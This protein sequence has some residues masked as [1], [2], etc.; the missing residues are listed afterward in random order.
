MLEPYG[1]GSENAGRLVQSAD[2][3]VAAA[4]EMGRPVALKVQSADIPHKTEAGAVILHLEGPDNVRAG[5]DAVL[6]A[7]KNFAPAAH[8][9]GVLVQR[10]APPGREVILGV[11]HDATFGPLLLVGLGGVLAEALGDV[12]VAPVPLD[13]GQARALIGRLKAANIFGRYRG[14]PPADIDALSLLM[15]RLSQF[16]H[17]HAEEILAIDLNPVIVHS[18]GDGVSVVDALITKRAAAAQFHLARE[19]E[20][21]ARVR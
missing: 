9:D 6:A 5:F 20:E 1:I 18:A 17:D 16:A 12:A 11:S 13:Q 14:L 7:A 3:A 10:M 4:R 2:E 21:K 19:M 8:I 15:V